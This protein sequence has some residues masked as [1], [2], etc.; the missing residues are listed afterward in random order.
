MGTVALP[1]SIEGYLGY[2]RIRIAEEV[3]W[4]TGSPL[5][6]IMTEGG[7]GTFKPGDTSL[8]QVLL[9]LVCCLAMSMNACKIA[10]L[11]SRVAGISFHFLTRI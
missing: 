6:T 11:V 3:A 5:Y 7:G 2:M 4:M 8:V 10:A 1:D 9:Q